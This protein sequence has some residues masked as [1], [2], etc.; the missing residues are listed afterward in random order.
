M[1]LALQR[2][3]S[4]NCMEQSRSFFSSPAAIDLSACGSALW[5]FDEALKGQKITAQTGISLE[6]E[7]P[8][9]GT[10]PTP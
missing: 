1:V 4:H 7:T 10:R 8:R 3:A 5:A 6:E 2:A 9:E